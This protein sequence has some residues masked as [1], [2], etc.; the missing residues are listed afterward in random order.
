MKKQ[1][2][3]VMFAAGLIA[4]A[5]QITIT[6]SSAAPVNKGTVLTRDQLVAAANNSGGDLSPSDSY[7]HWICSGWFFTFREIN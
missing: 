5:L 1:N 7:C 4:V 2:L 3:L 6:T